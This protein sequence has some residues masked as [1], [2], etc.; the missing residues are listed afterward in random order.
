[1]AGPELPI[2]Q[3]WDVGEPPGYVV[4]L[5]ATFRARNPDMQHQLFDERQAEEFISERFGERELAAFRSC[6]V[7][8]MRADYFRYCAVLAQGGIYADASFC[9]VSPLGPLLGGPDRG[10]LFRNASPG[11]VLN[12]FFGFAA[13]GHPLL[14]LALDLATASIERRAAELVQMVTGPGVFTGLWVLHRL[15]STESLHREASAHGLECLADPFRREAMALAPT[16]AGRKGVE[17]MVEPLFDT[18]ADL[19]RVEAAFEGVRVAP[20]EAMA[21]LVAAPE[22]PLPHKDDGTYWINWQRQG[23]TIFR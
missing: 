6:A 19:A 5:L 15:G 17:R 22:R 8:A 18:V 13:P 10:V 11:F 2:V 16:A 1:M 7:P 14:R 9:C 4:D 3:Y 21:E 20:Y 23:R 12:G